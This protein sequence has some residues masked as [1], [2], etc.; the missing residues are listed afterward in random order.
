MFSFYEKDI[1]KWNE[2]KG[3]RHNGSLIPSPLSNLQANEA[4][5]APVAG[6]TNPVS[7]SF[8]IYIG[9]AFNQSTRRKRPN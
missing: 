2:K 9:G 7:V 1:E 3:H 8:L 4:F 6:N 5:D